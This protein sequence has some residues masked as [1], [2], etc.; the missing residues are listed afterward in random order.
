MQSGGTTAQP[1]R[2]PRQDHAATPARLARVRRQLAE[3][4]VE[5]ARRGDHDLAAVARWL[6]GESAA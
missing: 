3:R 1:S 5:A 4:T 6:A 2:A